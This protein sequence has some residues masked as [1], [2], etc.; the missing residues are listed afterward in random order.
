M[1]TL[2]FVNLFISFKMY[3]FHYTLNVAYNFLIFLSVYS[4]LFLFITRFFSKFV[5][6]IQKTWRPFIVAFFCWNLKMFFKANYLG[7]VN[8]FFKERLK[9]F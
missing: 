7:I 2:L 6:L 4:N 3:C 9:M 5:A 8:I 1:Q